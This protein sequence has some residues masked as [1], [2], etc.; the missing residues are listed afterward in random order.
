MSELEPQILLPSFQELLRRLARARRAA[1]DAKQRMLTEEI[2]AA[3]TYG[4]VHR[5]SAEREAALLTY[6]ERRKPSWAGPL[7]TPRFAPVDY[8]I[9]DQQAEM[10]GRLEAAI[11]TAEEASRAPSTLAAR[12]AA[13][14]LY[15]DG[16]REF[17]QTEVARTQAELSAAEAELYS[18]GNDRDQ[19]R[20]K[21]QRFFIAAFGECAIQLR[22]TEED[23]A[24]RLP[25]EVELP[26]IRA[27]RW[28]LPI[29]P[30]AHHPGVRGDDDT[31]TAAVNSPIPALVGPDEPEVAARDRRPEDPVAPIRRTVGRPSTRS[32]GDCVW[33]LKKNTILTSALGAAVCLKCA[34]RFRHAVLETTEAADCAGCDPASPCLQCIRRQGEELGLKAALYR[35]RKQRAAGH[36]G[37]NE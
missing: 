35:P 23:I 14:N 21:Y 3:I 33:C 26:P 11:N 5:G 16:R 25:A 37:V 31:V 24:S 36:P 9:I 29:A 8:P 30:A 18:W 12:K 1:D 20:V 22:T 7:P 28:A 19:S 6:W 2:L 34:D 27:I 10:D 13:L 32:V 17:L 15:V 4:Q